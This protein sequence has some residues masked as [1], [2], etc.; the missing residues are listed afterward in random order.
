MI[1]NSPTFTSYR[2]HRCSKP[3][4]CNFHNIITLEQMIPHYISLEKQ[5][6]QSFLS[7]CSPSIEIVLPAFAL[8]PVALR[9]RCTHCQH[10]TSHVYPALDLHSLDLV[11]GF[12]M[13]VFHTDHSFSDD[14]P[15]LAGVLSFNLFF[16]SSIADNDLTPIEN[17]IFL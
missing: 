2:C 7:A 12:S 14:L 16:G 1:L 11:D 13:A 9:L 10:R 8:R 6:K 17:G 3:S 15:T 4:I 5:L